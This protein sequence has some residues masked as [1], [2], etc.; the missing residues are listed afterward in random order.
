MQ[1]TLWTQAR[2]LFSKVCPTEE[3]LP[4]A[5]DPEEIDFNYTDEGYTTEAS[6]SSQSVSTTTNEATATADAIVEQT[7]TSQSISQNHSVE[8]NQQNNNTSEYVETNTAAAEV[9]SEVSMLIKFLILW[10]F[11]SQQVGE[12][13]VG[14]LLKECLRLCSI[15]LTIKK[16]K[17]LEKN[18]F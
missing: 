16:I 4:R 1:L 14:L 10:F 15:M 13:V 5:P 8:L 18:Y 6:G 2:D 9:S 12:T 17:T 11:K 7:Q 3:F